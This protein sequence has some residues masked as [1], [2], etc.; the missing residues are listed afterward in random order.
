M[1]LKDNSK[2]HS[3]A[4]QRNSYCAVLNIRAV[5]RRHNSSFSEKKQ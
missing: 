2:G 3:N 4:E 5:K 1:S